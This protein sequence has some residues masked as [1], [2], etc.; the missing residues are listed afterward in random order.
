MNALAPYNSDEGCCSTRLMQ[1]SCRVHYGYSRC[2]CQRSRK[3]DL[4]IEHLPGSDADNSRKNMAANKITRLCQGT[5][6]STI[7]QDRR[8]T[9]RPY[10]HG[11]PCAFQKLVAC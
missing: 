1:C 5:L 2:N 11:K 9:E 3:P 8:S 6:Y 7:D 10:Y 4:T